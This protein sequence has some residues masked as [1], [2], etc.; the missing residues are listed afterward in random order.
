MATRPAL[1]SHPLILPILIGR[2]FRIRFFFAEEFVR[3]LFGAKRCNLVTF[4][5]QQFVIIRNRFLTLVPLR[6]DVAFGLPE[7]FASVQF[8]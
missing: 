3:K 4:D 5:L 8:N 1:F 2:R 7:R 6:V